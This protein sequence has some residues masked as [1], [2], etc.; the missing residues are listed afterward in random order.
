MA[1]RPPTAAPPSPLRDQIRQPTPRGRALQAAVLGWAFLGIAL[2]TAIG[3]A[4]ALGQ[5]FGWGRLA[6][7]LL[8]AALMTAVVVPGIV[9]L[10]RRLDHRSLEGLGVSRSAA[11][12]VALGMAVGVLTGLLVWVPAGLA[13]WIRVDELDVAA[14]LGFLL[15]N[16]VVL[17]LYEAL[18]EELALRGYVWTN[19]RDGWGPAVATL[20]TTALFPFI[21][22]V[23]GPVRWAITTVLGGDGGGIEVFPAGN[24]PV[25]YIVQL[26]LFG[27]ALVAARRIPVPG[28]L[29][30]AIA[31]HWTQLTV[32]RTVL[33]GMGWIESGWAI[34]W[35]EPDAIALVLVHIMLAGVA[36]VALRRRLQRRAG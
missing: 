24:D 18:P 3:V 13:G 22:L 17:A 16:G 8:Q 14:F 31:F 15:L 28:A 34:T 9:L 25:I 35:V 7:V 12:P 2:G 6:E 21:G 27:L 32:T 33:G 23:V 20:V 36:F 29:W 19:L 26:V 11:R 4:E 5:A 30:V 1:A 10:R